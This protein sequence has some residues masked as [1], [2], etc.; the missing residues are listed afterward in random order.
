VRQLLAE[1]DSA[2]LAEWQAYY[3]LEPF[4]EAVADQRH[5]LAVSVLANINR[6]PKREPY[7]PVDFIPWHPSHGEADK[8][9]FDADPKKQSERI[10][11]L[12]RTLV[13]QQQ[14]TQK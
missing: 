14:Q 6:N 3:S 11:G 5:G 13:A 12:F 1:I 4:G 7:R 2:E 10:K 9:L 8:P